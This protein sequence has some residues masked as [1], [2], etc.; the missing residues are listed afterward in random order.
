MEADTT[1][2]YF[3]ADRVVK[4]DMQQ[5]QPQEIEVRRYRSRLTAKECSRYTLESLTVYVEIVM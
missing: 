2:S 1:L 4:A 3:S 5:I